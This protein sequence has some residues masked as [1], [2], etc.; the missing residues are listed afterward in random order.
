[1]ETNCRCRSYLQAV[2]FKERFVSEVWVGSSNQL[3]ILQNETEV[4]LRNKEILP[5][6][7]SISSC[8]RVSCLPVCPMDFRLASPHNYVS[9]FLGINI[10][11]H[12]HVLLVLFL[13]KTLT[14]T[15]GQPRWKGA[16]FSQQPAGSGAP[17]SCALE[18]MDFANNLVE[19]G[20]S[21]F[22]S[23]TSR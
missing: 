13:W 3:K 19:F 1:M 20:N 11:G 4:S 16:T 10:S 2:D 8:L 5:Q 12:T 15:L 21:L 23:Q 18:E 9:Q 17:P 14:V 6:D 7:Y 22:F